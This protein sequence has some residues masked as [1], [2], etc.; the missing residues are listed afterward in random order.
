MKIAAF[1]DVHS[2]LPALEAVLDDIAGWGSDVQIVVAGDFL[3]FGPFPHK[4]LELIRALP[5]AVIIAGN[6]EEYV[7]DNFHKTRNGP[8]PA[9]W[10]ALYA[11]SVWTASQL[12]AQDIEWLEKLPRQASLPGPHG[13]DIQIVHGSPRRQTEGLNQELDNRRLTEIFAEYVRPKRLWISGHIHRPTLLHWRGMTVTSNGAVG[14]SL[15]GDVRACY[16]RAE[17]DETR[18]DWHAEHCRVAYD[19]ARAIADNVANA[20]HDQAGPFMH[21]VN[22]VIKTGSPCHITQ[23]VNNYV[24]EGG[25]PASPHDFAHLE[26][27][28]AAHLASFGEV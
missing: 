12:T 25:Y 18:G 2:N 23:F 5:N 21:L 24:A 4:I 19:R 28:V 16:L 11:P 13:S 10:R 8:L 1:S 15:D 27:A 6:H 7:I 9:P 3:N 14:M 17:W 20:A 26:K 22:Y